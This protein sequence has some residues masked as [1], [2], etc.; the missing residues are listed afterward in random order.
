MNLNSEKGLR[1]DQGRWNSSEKDQ[2][3]GKKRLIE[4]LWESRGNTK[5]FVAWGLGNLKDRNWK[6]SKIGFAGVSYQHEKRST[7]NLWN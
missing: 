4:S 6:V 7:I 5:L 1:R 2:I 3:G